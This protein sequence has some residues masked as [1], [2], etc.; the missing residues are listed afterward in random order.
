MLAVRSGVVLGRNSKISILNPKGGPVI[1]IQLFSR[2]SKLNTEN[3]F[4]D[5]CHSV[6]KLPS[7]DWPNDNCIASWRRLPSS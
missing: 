5:Y 6:L 7:R 3:C 2:I 1:P 4:I